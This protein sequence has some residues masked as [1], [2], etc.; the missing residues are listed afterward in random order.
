MNINRLHTI[1][2]AIFSILCIGSFIL[3]IIVFIRTR[4]ET[5]NFLEALR[6]VSQKPKSITY[7]ET[8][9]KKLFPENPKP[10]TE[11]LSIQS[12]HMP[13][14]AFSSTGRRLPL[15]SGRHKC[16]DRLDSDDMLLFIMENNLF[17]KKSR[18]SIY[19]NNPDGKGIRSSA[20]GL[21]FADSIV[22]DSLTNM[23]WQQYSVFSSINFEE[24]GYAI[25]YLNSIKWKG[26]NNWRVPTIEEIML[27]LVP[28]RNRYG[29]HLPGN[30]KCNA[31]DIWS[32]NR[33]CDSL[34]T[35]WI[36]VVRLEKGRCNYGHPAI[37]RAL[38]AVRETYASP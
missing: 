22:T 3:F 7:T 9:S 5:K 4:I 35:Q 11:T 36:W 27:L 17:C 25:Q 31:K 21:L 10:I 13:D 23:M 29:L 26:F 28:K 6:H 30:W 19:W 37:P 20:E 38:L 15:Y 18:W 8:D 34:S 2:I 12:S 16:G 1:I 32:C 24:I 33:A 14:S